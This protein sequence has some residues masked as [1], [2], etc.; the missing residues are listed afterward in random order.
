MSGVNLASPSTTPS[1]SPNSYSSSTP[2]TNDHAQLD[3]CPR[4]FVGHP[5]YHINRLRADLA[6]FTFLLGGDTDGA[7]F[8]PPPAHSNTSNDQL[9][10]DYLHNADVR[11][12]S[13]CR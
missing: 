10:K 3:A 7:L 1:S 6:R 4:R 2:G 12:C 5:A 11:T 9:D 8:Q 13:S